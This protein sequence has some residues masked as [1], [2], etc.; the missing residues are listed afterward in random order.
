MTLRAICI[1]KERPSPWAGNAG[2]DP[3][4]RATSDTQAVPRAEAR[5]TEGGAGKS[6]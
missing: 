2:N 6:D 3:L 1:K 4:C 5:G